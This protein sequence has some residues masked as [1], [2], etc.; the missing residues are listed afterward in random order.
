MKLKFTKMHGCGNDYIYVNCFDQELL[1]PEEFSRKFSQRR[2]GIGSDG[3][4]LVCPSDVADAKMRMFNADGSEG[5][6]CGNGIRCVGKFLSD[7]NLA[8]SK[9]M[10]V[11]TLSGIKEV[12]L[13]SNDGDIGILKVNMG[14]PDFFAGNIPVSSNKSEVVYE[15]FY[16]DNINYKITCLSMGNPHCVVFMNDIDNIDI[17]KIGPSFEKNS[18]FPEGVNTE[19]TEVMDE[20][21][22]KMRVW[23]RGSGET[24]AC[25]T[26]AC[27]SAVASVRNGLCEKGKDI[28]VHLLGGKLIINYS[29]NAVHMTGEAKKI[30][31]G[32]VA[33]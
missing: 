7:N 14:A 16:I 24:S 6:M 19:F 21:N 17:E 12:L 23:E 32:E 10:T 1:F 18:I 13:L 9:K 4:I 30:F 28:A 33:I 20:S 31:E 8:L 22:I 26:G 5:K 15:D 27:A 11:E 29:N 3:L 2:Y 25:G